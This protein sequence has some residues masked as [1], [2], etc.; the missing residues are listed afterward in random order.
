MVGQPVEMDIDEI[1]SNTVCFDKN[2][3][4]NFNYLRNKLRT[5]R[6]YNVDLFFSATLDTFA[7]C[8]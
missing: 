7:T 1:S 2:V 5:I 4:V 8:N 6:I 3:D